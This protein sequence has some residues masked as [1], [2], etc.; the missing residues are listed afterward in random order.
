MPALSEQPAQTPAGPEADADAFE[1]L[2]RQYQRMVHSVCYR[3]TGSSAE[4]DD[5]AQETFIAAF[6]HFAEFRNQAR[7]S[8]WLYRIA[9]NLCLNW[10]DKRRRS[11]R[12]QQQWTEERE[13][14]GGESARVGQVQEALLK[15]DPK[16]RATVVLTIFDQLTHAEAARALGC[17]ETTV[18]WRMFVARRK[19]KRLLTNARTGVGYD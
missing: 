7:V 9:M 18:S 4:A 13:R 11:E 19:L 10:Q 16:Q 6:K 14:S 3:M 12:L 15:L 5:L 1:D 8:S 17:S 2:V